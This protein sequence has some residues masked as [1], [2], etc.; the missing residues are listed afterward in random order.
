MDE[1]QAQSRLT[2]WAGEGVERFFQFFRHEHTTAAYSATWLAAAQGE[3]NLHSLA[4]G[5]TRCLEC[6]G[7]RIRAP[8]DYAGVNQENACRAA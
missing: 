2:Y 8:Y 6:L 3:L 1:R 7:D 5:Q 4:F